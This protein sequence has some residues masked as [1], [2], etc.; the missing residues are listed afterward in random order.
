MQIRIIRDLNISKRILLAHKRNDI[1]RYILFIYVFFEIIIKHGAEAGMWKVICC[2]FR[3]SICV[4]KIPEPTGFN[5]MITFI[6]QQACI[7]IINKRNL[8]GKEC[9]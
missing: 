3:S 8:F 6:I 2:D 9:F 1:T 4:L 7:I 5:T